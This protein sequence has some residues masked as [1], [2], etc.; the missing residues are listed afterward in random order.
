[1]NK[2]TSTYLIFLFTL[3]LSMTGCDLGINGRGKSSSTNGHFDGFNSMNY[4]VIKQLEWERTVKRFLPY[5]YGTLTDGFSNDDYYKRCN[6]LFFSDSHIDRWNEK[7]SLENVQDTISF[8]NE[9]PFELSAVV[10]AGD[11]ITKIGEKLEI[12]EDIRVFMDAIKQSRYPVAFSKG[13]HDSNDWKNA[14]SEVFK[15]EDWSEIIY[16]YVEIN[17]GMV[18]Q[19]KSNGQKSSYGYIDLSDFKI[20]I[21]IADSQDIDRE[22]ANDDGMAKYHCGNSYYISNEQLNWLANTALSF[23]DKEEKDWGVIVVTHQDGSYSTS[24]SPS[25][26]SSIQKFFEV[27]KAFNNQGIYQNKYTYYDNSF[28][29]IDVYANYERYREIKDKPHIIC[30]LLGHCHQD[31]YQVVDGINMI[32]ILNGSATNKDSDARVVRELGT[33]SQNAFDLISIDTKTRRIRCVRYGA[34]VNSHGTGGD[35][36]L[37]DG[38]S[39]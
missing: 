16:D 23:D 10:H 35:R 21:V 7:E 13:N 31:K 28:F 26:E 2:K 32:W 30:W 1:M 19:I 17:W 14:A 25:Y 38:L 37:P 34:G 3:S 18:R 36:F 11:A 12:K 15:D 39:Y 5:T 8:A 20:R 6:L 4:S 24:L 22:A 29:D 33:F 27:C 9:A